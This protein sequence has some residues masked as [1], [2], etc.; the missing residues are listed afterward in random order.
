MGLILYLVFRL[1]FPPEEEEKSPEEEQPPA[2]SYRQ[3]EI[4][5]GAIIKAVEDLRPRILPFFKSV[6]FRKLLPQVEAAGRMDVVGP[7]TRRRR[8]PVEL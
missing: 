6:D 5:R 1:L 3:L 8:A 7:A 4:G 2:E